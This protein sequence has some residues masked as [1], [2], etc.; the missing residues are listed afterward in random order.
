MKTMKR[1]RALGALTLA[2]ALLSASFARQA[3]AQ[4]CDCT[5]TIGTCNAS[6]QMTPTGSQKGGYG[7]DLLIRADAP[8]C[9]KVEYFVDSTPAFTILANGRQDT[10]RVMGTSEKPIR[11]RE[12]VVDACHVCKT[13]DQAAADRAKEEQ[14]KAEAEAREQQQEVERLVAEGSANGSLQPRPSSG[15]GGTAMDS[16][17]QLQSQ[18][19]SMQ[20]NNNHAA[21][22][23]RASAQSTS[24]GNVAPTRSRPYTCPHG[25]NCGIP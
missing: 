12:I 20:T 24:K 17:M 10:D 9:A 23:T 18:L 1:R 5:Q 2:L 21:F 13:A 8:A 15:S 14:Q 7:A 25:D 22:G 16:V 19:Q 11:K 6:I 4:A 3:R